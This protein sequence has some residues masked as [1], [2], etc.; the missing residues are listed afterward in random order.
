MSDLSTCMLSN[1]WAVSNTIGSLQYN[2]VADP[3]LGLF[4]HPDSDLD[5]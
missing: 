3:D 4:D 1:I 2:S 5:P